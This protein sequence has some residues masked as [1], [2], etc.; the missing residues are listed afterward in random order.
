[1]DQPQDNPLPVI[2]KSNLAIKIATIIFVMLVGLASLYYFRYY[3]GTKEMWVEAP[4]TV[5][6]NKLSQYKFSFPNKSDSDALEISAEMFDKPIEIMPVAR[7]Q[8]DRSTVVGAVRSNYWAVMSS[9]AEWVVSNIRP[10]AGEDVRKALTDDPKVIEI[11]T[12]SYKDKFQYLIEGIVYDGDASAMAILVSPDESDNYKF[13]EGWIFSLVD[14]QW[15]IDEKTEF[16]ISIIDGLIN[17]AKSVPADSGAVETTSSAEE[18]DGI[19]YIELTTVENKEGIKK[20]FNSVG[21]I[22]YTQGTFAKRVDTFDSLD[23]KLSSE[24]RLV[25]GNSVYVCVD[26]QKVCRDNGSITEYKNKFVELVNEKLPDWTVYPAEYI[27]EDVGKGDEILG[28]S[29]QKRGLTYTLKYGGKD[30]VH[31][32]TRRILTWEADDPALLIYKPSL[33]IFGG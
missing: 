20:G 16:Y 7:D 2:A 18:T 3:R 15:L 29:T 14:G 19:K 27:Y 31:V 22:P 1:M 23:A 12:N 11:V 10:G 8:A 33:Y 26:F 6:E 9:N 5:K 32:V 25:Y 21:V 30:T 4:K 24:H 28:Y 13:A 17:G